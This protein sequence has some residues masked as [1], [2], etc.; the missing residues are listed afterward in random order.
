MKWTSSREM[1]YEKI[2]QRSC[3]H[4][5][6]FV[7]FIRSKNNWRQVQWSVHDLFFVVKNVEWHNQQNNNILTSLIQQRA[8]NFARPN[9][10]VHERQRTSGT[11]F[12]LN[13]IQTN[14]RLLIKWSDRN[15]YFMVGAMHSK[16]IAHELCAL[17]IELFSVCVRSIVECAKR[18]KWQHSTI[19]EIIT[20]KPT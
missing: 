7:C 10:K 16:V 12:N 6:S 18:S 13:D 5:E 4:F 8:N 14:K 2:W 3:V 19:E 17:T 15:I 1:L 9:T 11:Y 20:R